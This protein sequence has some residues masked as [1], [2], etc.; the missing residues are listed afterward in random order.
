MVDAIRADHPAR[1]GVPHG[2]G[3]VLHRRR[4]ALGEAQGL[5]RRT[6]D[7]ALERLEHGLP[8]RGGGVHAAVDALDHPVLCL[9]PS[10][11][12]GPPARFGLVKAG[13]ID[14]AD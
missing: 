14:P 8:R 11:H 5:E 10:G 6:S 7:D 4:V 3:H 2:L 12:C 9:P 1:V 13:R